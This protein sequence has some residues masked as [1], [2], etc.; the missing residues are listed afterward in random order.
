M[1]AGLYYRGIKDRIIDVIG[2]ELIDGITYNITRPRNVGGAEL[3]G[4]ELAGQMFF[5]FSVSRAV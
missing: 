1:S 2:P 5:D 3:Q 4:I